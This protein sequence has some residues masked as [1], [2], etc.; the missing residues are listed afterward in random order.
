MPKVYIDAGHGGTDPGTHHIED[1]SGARLNEKNITLRTALLLQAYVKDYAETI[2][3]RLGDIYSSPLERA[4]EAN[5]WGADVYVSLHVNASSNTSASGLWLIYDD[6]TPADG[7][8]QLAADMQR[9]LGGHARVTAVIPDGTGHTSDRQLA[10]L[11]KTTMPAVLVELGFLSNVTDRR[12]LTNQEWL[13]ET[14]RRISLAI[15]SYLER[16]E[17][18]Q[19]PPVSEKATVETYHFTTIYKTIGELTKRVEALEEDRHA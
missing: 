16:V 7:G 15:K 13:R 6:N 9:E 5:E 19:E 2:L 1:A 10:V 14:A 18:T 11:S 12:L 8:I 4:K 17:R 3:C